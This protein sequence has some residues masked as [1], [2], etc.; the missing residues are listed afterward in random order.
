MRRQ[1]AIALALTGAVL[2]LGA[3]ALLRS[4]ARPKDALQGV[5]REIQAVLDD[6]AAGWNTSDLDRFVGAYERS[7]ATTYASSGTL[8]R[9]FDAI[10]KAY[11]A[12]W[13]G[14][15]RNGTLRLELLDLRLIGPRHTCVVGRY[16]LRSFGSASELTGITSLVFRRTAEGWRIIAD[17]S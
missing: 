3:A 10:R 11:Q 13:V 12:R 9:G 16:H 17:Q 5:R 15:G 14:S 2:G 8:M 7:A 6:S 4:Q 1:A